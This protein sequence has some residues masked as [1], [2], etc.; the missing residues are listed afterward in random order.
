MD[1]NLGEHADELRRR[2]RDLIA[3]HVPSD[4]LG[5]F[6]DEPEDLAVAQRF[7]KI[8]A[9]EELLAQAWPR[10]YGGAGATI[11][12]QAVVREEM[13][14]HHEPRGAQYMGLNWVGPAIMRFGNRVQREQHLP[15]IAAGDVIWCQGFSEPNAGSDLASLTTRARPT[16][17]GWAISGQKIWTSYALMAQWCVLLAR[18]SSNQAKQHGLTVFLLPMDR[19]GITVRGIPSMLGPHHLNEVFLDEV[20]AGPGDVLGTVDEGWTIIRVALAHERIGIARYARADR[21]LNEA[22]RAAGASW[23]DLPR[24][25]QAR[26]M[27]ALIQTRIAR[28]L[29]YRALSQD[30]DG[31][32]DDARASA[33]RIVATLCDQESAEVLMSIA[34]ACSFDDVGSPAI[35]LGR[36]IEDY[37]RYS[38]AATVASGTI[39]IQ[40]TL[41]ARSLLGSAK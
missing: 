1:Y 39:E 37:W 9:A 36:A 14:A 31:E 7:C 30:A 28:L 18:T 22:R 17:D 8:L 20:R 12:E 40:R 10:E 2:L 16:E 32:V 27:R 34:G 41:V 5:A 6:T 11:W 24:S 29:A 4:F 23:T 19:E 15:A 25:L 33:A 21:L 35:A 3:E 26:W 38:Q 13:W